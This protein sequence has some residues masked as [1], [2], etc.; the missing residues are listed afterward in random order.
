[1]KVMRNIINDIRNE[2]KE[3]NTSVLCEVY[4]EQFHQ[5]IVKSEQGEPLTRLQHAI[6]L[7]KETMRSKDRL[8]LLNEILPYSKIAEDDKD[9]ISTMIFQNGQT[10]ELDSVQISMRKVVK[11]KKTLRRI[12]IETLEVNNIKMKDIRT[13]HWKDIWQRYMKKSNVTERKRYSEGLNTAELKEM[14]EGT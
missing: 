14:I 9:E 5:I 8:E 13:S 3:Q 12:Y 6:G 1:M 7:F 11:R 4:D 10:K 2:L